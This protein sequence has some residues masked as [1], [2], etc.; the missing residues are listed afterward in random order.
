V[1]A[2]RLGRRFIANDIA[3]RAV[4]TARARLVDTTNAPFEMLKV[5]GWKVE[6]PTLQPS[7][8]NLQFA[9]NCVRLETDLDLDY[10]ELDPAWD[11]RVFR[12]AAQAVRPRRK[13]SLPT[14]I[15]IPAGHAGKAL[16]IR[17]VGVDGQ[18]HQR[19]FS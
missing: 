2:A 6:S 19:I 1:A 9:G 10:W 17:L 3:W 15:K 8:F 5:A 16:C 14:E 11:G 18:Q 4:H 7:T 13:G 12:S